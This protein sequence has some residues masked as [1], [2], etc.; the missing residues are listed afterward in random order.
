MCSWMA[1][2]RRRYAI[3]LLLLIAAIL[4]TPLGWGIA[5]TSHCA[6]HG[7]SPMHGVRSGT[8]HLGS[9]YM[10]ATWS[11]PSHTDC[12]HCP[13]SEC[14][15]LSPCATSTMVVRVTQPPHLVWFEAHSS[16]FLPAHEPVR[17]ATHQ[18]PTPPPQLIA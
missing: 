3:S 10:D 9:Q 4:S 7:A 17:S 8:G 14:A 18:P 6:Q 2:R 13:A 16:S 15:I 11:R 1:S 12:P 5:G